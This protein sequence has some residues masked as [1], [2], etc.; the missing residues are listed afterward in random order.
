MCLY[1][2]GRASPAENRRFEVRIL[3]DTLRYGV[4]GNTPGSEPGD[5]HA[6]SRFE[7]LYRSPMPVR[8]TAG[9]ET[10]NLHIEVR[11]LDGQ[12]RP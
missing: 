2:N 10:L 3:V 4:I 1:A 7:S 8:L 12:H 11:I 9:P 5:G 6:L